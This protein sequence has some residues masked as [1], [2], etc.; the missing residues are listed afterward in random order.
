MANIL[1]IDDDRAICKA[2]VGVVSRIGYDAAYAVTLKEGLN[3]V[4][5]G[6]YDVVFLDVRLPDG[7]GLD[8]LPE[9]RRSSS[10]PEVIIITGEGDPDGA[11]LAIKSGAWD[12]IEKP[13]SI[14]VMT[15]PLMRALQYRDEKRIK[16]PPVAIKRE[17]IIGDS[18]EMKHCLDLL[19]QAAQSDAGV[20]ITGETGTGKELFANA[21]HENSI[22]CSHNFVVVDCAA[23]P[24]TLVESVL[25]GHEKGAFTGADR[26]TE[27]LVKQADGGT[28]FLDEVGELPMS[29]Q[30]SFLRVLQE[31]RFR[32][33]GGRREIESD[34]RLIAATHRDLDQA[35]QDGKFRQDLLFRIRSIV[36]ELPPLRERAKDIKQ[37]AMYFMTKF[38]DRYETATKG[39]SP[40]FNEALAV[41]AWPGNV[42]E[43]DSC[44]KSILT[45]AG[46]APILYPKHL[47]TYIRAKM[48]RESVGKKDKRTR[49]QE[50]KGSSAETLEKFKDFRAMTLGEAEKAYLRNLMPLTQ[51]NIPAACQMSGLSRPRLY[52]L[53]KKHE[54]TRTR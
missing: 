24:K 31:R 2:L 46:D 16:K 6:L 29:I 39:F 44:L 20:L 45:T 37:L 7:N 23:L 22:R 38:C 40:E 9:I 25:F 48:A 10:S 51:W 47:P 42:R 8:A 5:S 52:A 4:S 3:M 28:L 32:P 21:I 34:F 1:I 43:L 11:E 26:T 54:I 33:V 27:G 19:V 15:L 50:K 36:I 13:L 12:Y 35:V 49:E 14:E 18:P 30:R 17:R 53:L 41:Y